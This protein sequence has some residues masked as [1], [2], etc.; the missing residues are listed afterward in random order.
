MHD[1]SVTS[2][3]GRRTGFAVKFAVVSL[4]SMFGVASGGDWRGMKFHGGIITRD[5]S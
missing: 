1:I 4:V 5:Y 2:A 3:I